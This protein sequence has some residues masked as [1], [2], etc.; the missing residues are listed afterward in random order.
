M[1]R[2]YES[3]P[4]RMKIPTL[5]KVIVSDTFKPSLGWSPVQSL[6]YKEREIKLIIYSNKDIKKA[7]DFNINK[8]AWFFFGMFLPLGSSWPG[9]VC[10]LPPDCRWRS[11]AASRT[12]THA[13]ARERSSTAIVLLWR[14]QMGKVAYCDV[15]ELLSWHVL[16]LAEGIISSLS[17][18]CVQ[19]C[20]EH[21]RHS[22]RDL[23][24]HQVI[25]WRL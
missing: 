17:G 20:D 16:P 6:R 21:H 11:S 22:R 2:R 5:D 9:L 18:Y 19:T 8:P 7:T 25:V 3:H 10:S 15:I 24:Q 14:Y 4:T 1:E 12:R 23:R 13:G